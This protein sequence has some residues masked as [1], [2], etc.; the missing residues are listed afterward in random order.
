MNAPQAIIRKIAARGQCPLPGL[1][2]ARSGACCW[3]FA[4]AWLL[5]PGPAR[6]GVAFESDRQVVK[7]A[8]DQDQVTADFTFRNTGQHPVAVVSVLSGCQCLVAE[9]PEKPVPPGETGVIHGVFKVGA[10]NG[11]VEKQM[12]VRLEEAGKT[13]DTILTVEVDVPQIIVIE[14]NTLT[15]SVG[16]A[17]GEQS[18]SV[19]IVWPE[20]VRILSLECSREEFEVRHETVV[21]GKEYKII[22]KPRDLSQPILG[23]VQVKTDCRFEKYRNPMAFLSIRKTR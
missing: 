11:R 12:T 6:A 3:L 20:P 17:P 8:P 22:A 16:A 23:L 7:A 21:E 1:S 13:T 19:R 10:F 14:P 4:L 5:P 9:G 18:F 15:W 2:P